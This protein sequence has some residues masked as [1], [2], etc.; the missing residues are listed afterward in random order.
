MLREIFGLQRVPGYTATDGTC[1]S[2]LG[3]LDT[4]TVSFINLQRRVMQR[5][6]SVRDYL[7]L[8]GLWGD[9][10]DYVTDKG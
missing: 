8:V 4:V 10:L 2:N 3:L 9:C 6:V 1:N 7:D 5:R